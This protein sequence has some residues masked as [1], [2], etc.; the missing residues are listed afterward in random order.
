MR[1]VYICVRSEE[2]LFQGRNKDRLLKLFHLISSPAF[3]RGFLMRWISNKKPAP[4]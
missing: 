3:G 4:D 2:H 1:L